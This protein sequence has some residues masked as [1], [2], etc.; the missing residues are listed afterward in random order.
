MKKKKSAKKRTLNIPLEVVDDAFA[1]E[2][3][4][5][6]DGLTGSHLQSY[7]PAP[8]SSIFESQPSF[9]ASALPALGYAQAVGGSKGASADQGQKKLYSPDSVKIRVESARN[10]MKAQSLAEM[11]SFLQQSASF[12]RED[13]LRYAE[14]QE[15]N[16]S[17]QH[18]SQ[19]Q[20]QEQAHREALARTTGSYLQTLN[21]ANP[22]QA[23]C[24]QSYLHHAAGPM[25][26]MPAHASPASHFGQFAAPMTQ[27]TT[28]QTPGYGTCK[29]G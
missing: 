14:L 4:T 29:T 12:S 28:N 15:R 11:N 23:A 20:S 2:E 1:R 24:Y 8:T 27:H 22:N 26:T 10:E 7:T 17:R 6:G 5:L 18:Q 19:V 13:H 9:G 16:A 25:P 21:N 3:F